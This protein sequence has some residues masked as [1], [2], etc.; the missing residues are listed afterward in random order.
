MDTPEELVKA[1]LSW[2]TGMLRTECEQLARA[3]L[4]VPAIAD[5]LARDAAVAEIVAEA[6]PGE[7]RG[8]AAARSTRIT[9]LYPETDK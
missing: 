7:S 5:A 2:R 3:V 9:A 6:E 8:V 4:A 1:M